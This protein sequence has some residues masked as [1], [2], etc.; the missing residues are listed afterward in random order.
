MVGHVISEL[1]QLVPGIAMRFVAIYR[2]DER[3]SRPPGRLRRRPRAS[4]RATRS[5]C[6]PPPRTFAGTRLAAPPGSS[7]RRVIIAGGGRVGLRLA[8]DLAVE[9]RVKLIESNAQRCEY[10]ATQL[11]SDTLVLNADSTDGEVLENENVRD[12]ELFIAVTSDDEDNIMASL[13]AKRM[14]AKRVLALINRR[15]YAD[16]VQGTQIDI[17][18]SPAQTVI[19][20][21]LMHVRRGASRGR[22]LAAPRRRRGTGGGRARR[23]QGLAG[24]RAAH[25]RARLAAG[26]RRSARLCAARA[27]LHRLSSRTAIRCRERRSRHRLPAAQAHGA[28]GRDACSRWRRRFTDV[29]PAARRRLRWSGASSCCSRC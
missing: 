29:A 6:S 1:P 25:R 26:R 20:E 18:L 11:P 10:L 9:C 4:S 21:L 24:G 12:T 5:S 3:G 14:G 15:A 27:T 19:G 2:T 22:V 17:A 7:R 16:L 28:R 8:R 13:L 23:P